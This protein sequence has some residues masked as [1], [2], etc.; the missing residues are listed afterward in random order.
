M[1][2]TGT[3]HPSLVSH[4]SDVKLREMSVTSTPFTITCIQLPSQSPPHPLECPPRPQPWPPRL[5]TRVSTTAPLQRFCLLASMLLATRETI[6]RVIIKH[7]PS[8]AERKPFQIIP[9]VVSTY[10]LS[11]WIPLRRWLGH[12]LRFQQCLPGIFKFLECFIRSG[13]VFHKRERCLILPKE[14]FQLHVCAQCMS[15]ASPTW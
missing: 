12:L 10:I 2:F 11:F 1:A 3:K 6:V 15:W 7:A 5:L 8:K 13:K 4:L 14:R 9:I